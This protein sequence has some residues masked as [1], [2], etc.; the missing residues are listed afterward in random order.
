MSFIPVRAVKCDAAGCEHPLV[1]SLAEDETRGVLMLS[2]D[3]GRTDWHVLEVDG[4][5]TRH[6]CPECAARGKPDWFPVDKW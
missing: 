5:P 4:Q 2:D 6:V 1:A 3:A